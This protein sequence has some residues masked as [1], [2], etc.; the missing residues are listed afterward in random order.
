MI[1]VSLT[2]LRSQ[3]SWPWRHGREGLFSLHPRSCS[4]RLVSCC[5][6]CRGAD[7]L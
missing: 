6:S 3:P 2:L 1:S 7:V 4:C 5:A